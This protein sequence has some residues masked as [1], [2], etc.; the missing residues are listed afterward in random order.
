[1]K[2]LVS[3]REGIHKRALEMLEIKGFKLDFAKGTNLTSKE[4]LPKLKKTDLLLVKTYTKVDKRALK[5]AKKLKTVIKC[6]VGLDNIDVDECK[7]LGVEVISSPGS[8]ANT[9]AEH[10][11]GLIFSVLRK[12]PEADKSVRRGEWDRQR[13]MSYELERKTIGVIGFGS[14]GRYVAKKLRGFD[15][16]ILVYDPYLSKDDVKL[17]DYVKDA[18]IKKTDNIKEVLKKSHVISIHVP[19]SEETEDLIGSKELSLMKKDSILINASRGG[20]VNEKA[21]VK[22]LKEGKIWG[23][24]LDVFTG[25]P[26]KNSE[27]FT[28]PNVVL[29]PHIGA[30]T[31][32]AQERMSVQSVALFLRKF[33][34]D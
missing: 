18:S 31:E 20:I 13:F 19:L 34:K 24:G 25:E 22:A 28:L 21:L 17:F 6:G 15:V 8:N 23:A 1:M 33:S 26:P 16:G 11:I 4:N 29:T 10:I 7:A 30:M 9:V 32:E 27:L 2:V 3:E 12:I 14:I 5:Q